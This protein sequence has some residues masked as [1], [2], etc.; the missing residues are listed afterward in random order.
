MR[1]KKLASQLPFG[2]LPNCSQPLR[3]GPGRSQQPGTPPRSL[4]QGSRWQGQG[5]QSPYLLLPRVCVNRKLDWGWRCDS[6]LDMPVLGCRRPKG[7]PTATDCL[8]L[9]VFCF[10][11]F[12]FNETSRIVFYFFKVKTDGEHLKYKMNKEDSYFT[13]RAK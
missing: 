9:R 12:S 10:V 2:S 8:P 11:F 3:D 5:L 4:M 7:C 1:E 6:T 13:S